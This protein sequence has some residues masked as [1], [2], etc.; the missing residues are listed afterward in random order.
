MTAEVAL[1][2]LRAL[3]SQFRVLEGRT[4]TT[5]TTKIAVVVNLLP[6]N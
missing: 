1:N 2:K 5:A 6:T 3:R 4:A